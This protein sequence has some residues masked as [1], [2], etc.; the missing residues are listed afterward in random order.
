MVIEGLGENIKEMTEKIVE[1]STQASD[2]IG[3]AF[4][5]MSSNTMQSV[6]NNSTMSAGA[7]ALSRAGQYARDTFNDK[8]INGDTE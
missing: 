4:I 1:Q 3:T 7:G 2:A 5:T 6:Q 8:M